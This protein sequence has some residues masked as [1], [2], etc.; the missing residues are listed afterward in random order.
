MNQPEISAFREDLAQSLTCEVLTD[1][2]SLHLYSTDASIFQIVPAAVVIPE[3]REQVRQAVLCASRH[4]VPVLPRGGG[5]SLAGQTVGPG[6]VIDCSKHMNR[7]LE[8]NADERWVRVEPGIVLDQLN[9]F[10]GPYGLF[11]APDVATSSRA[12]VGGMIGNNSSGTRSVLYGKTVDHVIE[13]STVLPGGDELV[14]RP[15]DQESLRRKCEQSDREGELYRSLMTIVENNRGLIQARFPK[16]MRRVSGYNLDELTTGYPLNL[17]KL[18][19]GSE[20]TLAV[21]TEAK[22]NLLPIPRCRSV[23]VLHFDQLLEAIRTVPYLLEY[24]PS[25][26]EVLDRYGLELAYGNP[27]VAGLCRTFIHQDPDAILIFELTGESEDE[28]R[29]TLSRVK[30]DERVSRRTYAVHEAWTGPEQQ[31]IW[32]VR[33]NALGVMLG[34]KGDFKPL[35]FVEDSCVPV[36]HLADYVADIESICRGHNRRLALYAHA[37]VGVIHLRPILNLKQ[38]E[39]VHILRSISE[40]AF[41]RVVQYGGSWS[42]EHGDGLVR[43][44]KLREFFGDELYQALVEV[45][46]AFDPD[47]IM[48]P[49]KIIDAQPPTEN[50]RISPAYQVSYPPTY[51]RFEDEGGFDRAIELCTGV[52][53]CRKNNGIMCPS[54]IATRD[55]EHSTRGR[56]NALRSA[57]A[58]HLGPDGFTSERLFEVLDLCLE[59]KACKSECPSN[60]DMAKMKAEFLA[61][62]YHAHDLPLRKRLVAETATAADTA[63]LMPSLVNWVSSNRLTRWGLDKFAGI[64][65]RRVLPAYARQTLGAWY[66]TSYEPSASLPEITLFAD[67]FTNYYEPQIGVAAIE[68]LD[69]LGFRVRLAEAGC[70]GRPLISSGLLSRARKEGGELMQRLADYPAP[71]IVLE[72]SCYSTLKDDYPDLMLDGQGARELADRV[73]TLEEFLEAPEIAFKLNELLEPG[74]PRILFHGHCQQKSLIGAGPTIRVLSR[75]PGVEIEQVPDGCCGMAGVFGYEKE[76]YD[77]S[78]KIGGLHLFP[79]VE[80]ADRST[81]LV[82]SGFSCRSQVHHFTGRTAVHPAVA[83]AQR[84]RNT[85]GQ[86]PS[87]PAVST[88]LE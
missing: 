87:T 44:Y 35:P 15:L 73:L 23:A 63:S 16:V 58:G 67:T 78:A 77:L 30:K 59:C 14:F 57:I 49:G 36:E 9:D 46:K 71:V 45:K 68:V 27:A 34:I 84:I 37:S 25:A 60:V 40:A 38:E 83:L 81:D 66:R 52:G 6:L 72:P 28:L 24:S 48:N 29:E 41:Q 17:A 19:V 53:Q 76:H 80:K 39:D 33:K 70:C 10:L 42:G 61:H 47:G 86:P 8:L 20:G 26:V 5:T 31:A 21:V 56:A 50:L 88:T 4:G 12:N 64:D 51:Y 3:N 2:V 65:R 69:A 79:A 55:E 11:F 43:S 18:L 75:I 82:V 54:Y 7:I 62:Y 74:S 22:L 85:I 13:L 1:P 32:S